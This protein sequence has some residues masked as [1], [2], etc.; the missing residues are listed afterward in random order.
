MSISLINGLQTIKNKEEKEKLIREHHEN[1]IYGG[2]VGRK[3]LLSKLKTKYTW[4]HMAKDVANVIKGCEKC[5][6]NKIKSH[7]RE[8]MVITPTP[9]NPFDTIIVDTIGPLNKT[10]SDHEYA[11]TIICDLS[12]YLIMVPV[13]NKSANSIAKAIIEHVILIF[14]PVKN[15]RTDRGTEYNNQLIKEIC[16]L[17]DIKHDLS[18]AYHHQTVGSIERNHRT[19]NEY[20]R[21]YVTNMDY[22]DEYIQYY[23]YCYNTSKHTAFDNKYSPYELVYGKTPREYNEILTGTIEP[24]YNIENYANELKF[25]LQ[26]ANKQAKQFVEKNKIINKKYYD[27]KINTFEVKSGDKIKIEKEPRNKYKPIYDG[28]FTV[29]EID[30]VNITYTDNNNKKRTVHKNRTLL[31]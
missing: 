4:K 25:K 21:I 5:K 7:T 10:E 12:K 8:P 24:V 17:L 19:L 20:I 26:V 18:T 13:K 30:G 31:Y 16:K 9:Q 3:K 1:R 15:I 29:N 2:H 22:W 27:H 14:G 28:P 23:T 11:V 6:L